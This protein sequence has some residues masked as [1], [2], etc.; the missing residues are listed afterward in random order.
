MIKKDVSLLHPNIAEAFMNLSLLRKLSAITEEEDQILRHGGEINR[1][2]Y[3][4]SKDFVIDSNRL[5][6]HRLS[7]TNRHVALRTHT[8][9]VEFPLHSHDFVEIMY[10]CSG[11]VTH[12]IGTDT[13]T[14]SEGD[15]LLLNTHARHK[16]LPAGREDVAIN[17]IIS[18]DF[19]ATF[20]EPLRGSEDL[21]EF[22]LENLRRD[23]QARYLHYN[24][25]GIPPML[26]LME[27][28]VYSLVSDSETPQSIFR[29]TMELLLS[30]LV[31][32]PETLRNRSVPYEKN[33][34]MHR[35]IIS[36]IEDSYSTASLN[37]LSN[38]LGF[39]VQYLSEWIRDHFGQ[40]FKTMLQEKRFTTAERL[41]MT[42]DLSVSE[43]MTAVGYENSSYFHRRF[44][45]RYGITPLA[46]RNRAKTTNNPNN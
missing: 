44:R 6:A 26:N 15:L 33:E 23:G 42:T 17:L 45:Q 13:L 29:Q 8:R 30:Y 37:E 3:T 31:L 40:T 41:L 20:L 38:Q 32:Y 39:S 46:Y 36:Y 25:S 5:P 10:V 4:A 27:N 12:V 35:K 9:F 19:F 2:L 1:D 43:I 28:L 21:T 11:H 7:E 18:V 22:V 34:M 16:V 14:L 24:I